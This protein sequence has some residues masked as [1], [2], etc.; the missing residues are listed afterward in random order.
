MLSVKK[1]GAVGDGATDDTVAIQAAADACAG[2]SVLFFPHPT[3]RY[4]ITAPIV[5]TNMQTVRGESMEG[6][7]IRNYGDD[8]A[9]Y[10]NTPGGSHRLTFSDLTIDNGCVGRTAGAG[11]HMTSPGAFA[12]YYSIENMNILYHQDGIRAKNSI[13]STIQ[14][15]VCN[16]NDRYGFYLEDSSNAVSFISTYA[17]HSG[18]HGYYMRGNYCSFD[19]CA[20]DNNGG[21]GYHF[22]STLA[23]GIYTGPS[24]VSLTSCGAEISAGHG[25]YAE[26][27]DFCSINGGYFYGAGGDGIH[28]EG[29]QF[30]ELGGV[31][32]SGCGGYSLNHITHVASGQATLALLIK[33]CYLPDGTNTQTETTVLGT[34]GGGYIWACSGV[35]IGFGGT[36]ITAHTSGTATWDPGSIA[37][38]AMTSTTVTVPGA[39]VGNTVCVGFSTAVPAGALLVGAV[40]AYQTVTVTLFNKTGGD[41]DLASGTLRADVWQH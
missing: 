11:I 41:L 13:V 27:P 8:D 31:Q 6:T 4:K 18:S 20:S 28:L 32:T 34:T 22:F 30:F 15:V 37:D 5:L 21:D 35:T 1:Y 17:C 10:H 24:H 2:K 9:F 14:N 16:Y 40:T 7:V 3:V 33:S 26:R 25:F 39:V 19:A 36:K 23:G 12:N 29:S 38:G